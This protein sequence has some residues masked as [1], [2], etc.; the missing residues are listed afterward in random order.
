[1]VQIWQKNLDKYITVFARGQA[2]NSLNC[3]LAEYYLAF[4]RFSEKAGS[5]LELRRLSL[6]GG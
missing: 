1:M 3:T 4:W 5:S 6:D 2:Q